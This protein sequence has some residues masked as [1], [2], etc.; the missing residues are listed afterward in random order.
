MCRSRRGAASVELAVLLPL[1]LFLF[2]IAVDYGRI[3]Y[4]SLILE[5]CARNGAIYGSDPIAAAQSPYSSIQQAA[6]A[7]TTNISPQPTVTS[8]N[9]SDPSGNPYVEATVV[10][11]FNSVGNFPGVPSTTIL[12]RKVRMR[13]APTTPK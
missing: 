13:V 10:W 7:E 5:N 1:L 8:A 12:S 6:L 2:M 3:F 9:G 4:Y 11:Q